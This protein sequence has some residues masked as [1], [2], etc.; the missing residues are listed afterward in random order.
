VAKKMG[1]KLKE[2]TFVGVHGRRTDSDEFVKRKW[3]D[4]QLGPEYYVDA[5]QYFRS[6][7]LALSG[8]SSLLS[9]SC[10]ITYRDEYES[11]AFLYVSDDMDWSR[12]HIKDEHGDLFFVSQGKNDDPDSIG[13]D[14]AIMAHSNHTVISRG[15]Y[16]MWG[17]LL[18]GGEY[19]TEYG[20]IVPVH[21]QES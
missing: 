2:I 4:E 8:K 9:P 11:V 17:S 15:T 5:M 18:C 1:K 12:K 6:Y 13:F 20:A 14:L 19:Y 3:H 10:L 16:S 21:L 7:S